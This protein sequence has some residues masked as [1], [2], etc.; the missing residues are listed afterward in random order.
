MG[1]S[2]EPPPPGVPSGPN[3]ISN[4]AASVNMSTCYPQ[5]FQNNDYPHYEYQYS[6]NSHNTFPSSNVALTPLQRFNPSPRLDPA[7]YAPCVSNQFPGNFQNNNVVQHRAD[8]NSPLEP[9]KKLNDGSNSEVHQANVLEENHNKDMEPEC[10]PKQF[11]IRHAV[12][13]TQNTMEQK[14]PKLNETGKMLPSYGH[15]VER[16]TYQ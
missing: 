11:G 3:Y 10:L 1:E 2:N 4:S 14:L 5:S 9:A 6:Y 12:Q 13:Y 8:S 7:Q 16:R 15:T